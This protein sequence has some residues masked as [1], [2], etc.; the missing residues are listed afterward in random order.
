MEARQ[1]P[2]LQTYWPDIEARKQIAA[3]FATFQL[4]IA[5]FLAVFFFSL[6]SFAAILAPVAHPSAAPTIQVTPPPASNVSTY[7]PPL[8][9]APRRHR[10]SLTEILRLLERVR[11]ADKNMWFSEVRIDMDG[12]VKVKACFHEER[13]AFTGIGNYFQ[14][15][16]SFDNDFRSV[17]LKRTTWEPYPGSV[18][19]RSLI[20]ASQFHDRTVAAAELDIV[21]NEP[22]TN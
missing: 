9:S 8:R 2:N 5:V 3:K 17:R 20:C 21:L 4:R 19:S 18:F 10:R 12:R 16:K 7:Q 6:D 15:F 14:A 22:F 13:R 11:A 1:P